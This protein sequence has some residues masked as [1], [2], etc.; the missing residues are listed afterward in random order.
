MQ[1]DATVSTLASHRISL[2]FGL[3]KKAWLWIR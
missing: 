3:Y 2:P 1:R